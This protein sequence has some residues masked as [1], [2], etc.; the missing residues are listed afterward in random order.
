MITTLEASVFFFCLFIMYSTFLILVCDWSPG[1]DLAQL[2][3][4]IGRT[5]RIFFL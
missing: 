1:V 4:D 2:Q 3:W 5:N